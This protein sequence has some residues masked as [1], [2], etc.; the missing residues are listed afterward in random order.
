MHRIDTFSFKWQC[1]LACCL[2]GI[3]VE[4]NVNVKLSSGAIVENV[5]INLRLHV[6]KDFTLDSLSCI[7]AKQDE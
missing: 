5:N 1:L 4:S 2:D 6:F 3:F 7:L